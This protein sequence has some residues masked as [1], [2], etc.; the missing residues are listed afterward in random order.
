MKPDGTRRRSGTCARLVRFYNHEDV[1]ERVT[2]VLSE[3]R[4]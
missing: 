4:E 3:F 2:S 1:V